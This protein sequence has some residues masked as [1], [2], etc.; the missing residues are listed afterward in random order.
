MAGSAST[1][2]SKNPL[3]CAKND[4]TLCSMAEM[5]VPDNCEYAILHLLETEESGFFQRPRQSGKTTVLV[6]M[7]NMVAERGRRAYYIAMNVVAIEF[8]RGQLH[9][10][11]VTMSKH[12]ADKRLRGMGSGWVFV[13]EVPPEELP[14]WLLVGA[15]RHRLVTGFY[16]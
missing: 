9:P 13:D 1:R 6:R 16:T 7:A 4:C 11:V 15:G 14:P 3:V 10:D 5:D 8:L 2:V 12:N